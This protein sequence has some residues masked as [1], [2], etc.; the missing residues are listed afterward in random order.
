MSETETADRYFVIC[1]HCGYKNRDAWEMTGNDEDK[2]EHDC[3]ECGKPF[4]C[5]AVTSILYYADVLSG[6]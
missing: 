6:T 3:G 5:W 4:E 2:H 1:P